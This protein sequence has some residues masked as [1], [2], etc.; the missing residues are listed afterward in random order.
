W[1]PN[2]CYSAHCLF[3][4][5]CTLTKAHAIECLQVHNRL[6]LPT[7]V[8]DLISHLLNQ[9]ATRPIKHRANPPVN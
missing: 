5:L 2:S 6:Q 7:T 3:Q 8:V 9:L 4:P 1:L